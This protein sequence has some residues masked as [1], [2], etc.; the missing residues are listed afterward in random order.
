MMLQGKARPIRSARTNATCRLPRAGERHCRYGK[1]IDGVA[2]RRDR[3]VLARFVGE[4]SGNRAQGVPKE[5]SE[6]G[7][8]ADRCG[9]EDC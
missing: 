9:H 7:N 4:V 2:G 8:D 5:L 3:P 1:E 6:A